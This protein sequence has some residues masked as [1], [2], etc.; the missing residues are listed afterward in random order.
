[1]AL[2]SDTGSPKVD[3]RLDYG[4]TFVRTLT[5][6][7]DGTPVDFNYYDAELLIWYEK[8]DKVLENFN[9]TNGKIVSMGS[10]VLSI[11]QDLTIEPGTYK[12]HFMIEDGNGI[13]DILFKG[14]LIYK[15]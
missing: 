8:Q 6:T 13:K 9:L 4:E 10:G 15:K 7:K 11:A 14:D 1:M 3:F 2:L 5:I 12:H